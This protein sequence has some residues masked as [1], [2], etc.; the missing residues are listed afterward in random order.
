MLTID[1]TLFIQ[2]AVF[3]VLFYLLNRFLY[4]PILVVLEER[5]R[6]T[7]GTFKHA[8][9]MEQEVA[10]GLADYEKSLREAA[11]AT[12]AEM[13]VAREEAVRKE[14]ELIEKMRADAAE[15]L[16]KM[17]A[18]LRGNREEAVS[19]LKKEAPQ[20][21]RTIAEKMLGR[22]VPVLIAALLPLF[23]TIAGAAEEGGG[24]EGKEFLWKGINF[25]ILVAVIYV[26]W[27]KW[28]RG[29]LEGRA[30]DIKKTMEEAERKKAEAEERLAEYKEK[31]GRLDTEIEETRKGI[32][33][34]AEVER[35][36]IIAE[37]EAVAA[38]I[39]EQARLLVE[40]EIKSVREEICG[41]IAAVAVEMAA[42][43]LSR[44][45]KPADQERVTKG[46]LEKLRLN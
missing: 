44:E 6:R 38:R 45:M 13:G 43:L 12:Q 42:D 11:A 35:K 15:D 21:A 25:A 18:A 34:E 5:K 17:K 31:L 10:K 30:V 8:D 20:M 22:A 33:L 14:K 41:E 29:S 39:M 7:V 32:R 4:G 28:L 27:K 3:F 16:V 2:M 23:S 19:A 24:H 46:Y 37:A 26:V 36:R 40:Q 9:G 1:K